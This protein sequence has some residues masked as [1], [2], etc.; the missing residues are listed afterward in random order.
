MQSLNRIKQTAAVSE[1]LLPLSPTPYSGIFCPSL[2]GFIVRKSLRLNI[3][4]LNC[5]VSGFYGPH[6]LPQNT[7]INGMNDLT[8]T[9][10]KCLAP[11]P[12]AKSLLW[13]NLSITS[14]FSVFCAPDEHRSLANSNKINILQ[15]RAGKWC[16]IRRHSPHPA[17]RASIQISPSI[18][19][20]MYIQIVASVAARLIAHLNSA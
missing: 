20:C 11:R 5:L 14:L 13:K 9:D 19:I 3:L 6:P 7:N 4:P 1:S 10:G 16:E 2:C 15:D 17:R 12:T 18:W 8:T